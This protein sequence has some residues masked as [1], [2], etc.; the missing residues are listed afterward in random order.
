MRPPSEVLREKWLDALLPMVGEMGWTT[1]AAKEAAKTAGLSDGEQA[2]AAPGGIRDL[3]RDFFDRAET[4]TVAALNAEDLEALRVHERVAFGV[5]TWLDTL[6]PHSAAVEKASAR[7]FLPWGAPDAG[8]RAWSVA[9]TVWTGIGD[10]SD[11]YNYYSKR[12]LLASA[13]PPIVLFWLKEPRSDDLD[14][15]IAARLSGAMRFGQAGSKILKPVL[16]RFSAARR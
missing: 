4:K 6:A 13:I 15:F 8:A 11:D 14:A 7:G 12:A 1:I 5:R 10:T 3:L 16:D 2:L 9:D